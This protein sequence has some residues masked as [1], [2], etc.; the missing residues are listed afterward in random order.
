MTLGLL[1]FGSADAHAYTVKQSS[2]GHSVHWREG[3]IRFRMDPLIAAVHGRAKAQAA[4]R[5]AADAWRGFGTAPDIE[6]APGAPPPYDPERRG[7]GIHLVDPWPHEADKLA[8]TVT[9]YGSDGRIIGAD[10]LINGERSFAVLEESPEAAALPVHD[11][12]AVLAHE[13]GHVLGLGESEDDPEAT[14]WPTIGTGEWHQRTLSED[15]EAGVMAIYGGTELSAGTAAVP[16]AGGCAVGAARGGK[17]KGTAI[18]AL[19]LGLGVARRPRT[20]LLSRR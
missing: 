10:I 8:L 6:L 2:H 19:L 7:N 12:A 9:T 11:L 14:M 18:G 13:F 15:D 1:A 5:I 4:V 3:T 17:G 20:R 16:N